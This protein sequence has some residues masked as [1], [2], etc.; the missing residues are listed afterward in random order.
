MTEF[1]K[2]KARDTIHHQD[3]VKWLSEPNP[4]YSSG[5]PVE[6]HDAKRFL[7]QSKD[8]LDDPSGMTGYNS[9]GQD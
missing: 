3:R 9:G 6:P 5:T 8:C 7:E 2:Q 1:K 4:K